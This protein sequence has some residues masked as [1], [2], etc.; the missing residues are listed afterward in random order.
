M[1]NTD[2]AHY[3]TLPQNT[4]S[5]G[6]AITKDYL[7]YPVL[8]TG[9]KSFLLKVWVNVLRIVHTDPGGVKFFV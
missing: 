4:P 1:P 3:K 6:W 5:Y 7:E 2:W 8:C 9:M